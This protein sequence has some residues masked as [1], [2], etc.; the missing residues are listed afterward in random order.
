[1][2]CWTLLSNGERQQIGNCHPLSA[3]AEAPFVSVLNAGL[4]AGSS[5]VAG[6]VIV[7]PPHCLGQSDPAKEIGFSKSASQPLACNWRMGIVKHPPAQHAQNRH[8]LGTPASW[9]ANINH[10]SSVRKGKGLVRIIKGRPTDTNPSGLCGLRIRTHTIYMAPKR[11]SSQFPA[12]PHRPHAESL[13]GSMPSNPLR[14]DREG[15]F[16]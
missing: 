5:T 10:D 3:A 9:D 11:E 4:K 16:S 6:A 12:R 2:I 7:K 1:M 15:F 13:E 14:S 8:T